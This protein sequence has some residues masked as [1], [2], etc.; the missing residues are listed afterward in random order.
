MAGIY[1]PNMQMPT[2]EE[3]CKF[4]QDAP[5][6]APYCAICG[7]CK[8]IDNCPLIAVPDHERLIDGEELEERLA[9]FLEHNKRAF[10]DFEIELFEDAILGVKESP[11]VIPADKEET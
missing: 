5:F 2:K 9:A 7:V 3:R 10:T 8:G 4:Y 6:R 11:T 1:I